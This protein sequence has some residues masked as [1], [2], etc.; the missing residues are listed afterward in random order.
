MTAA[1]QPMLENSGDIDAPASDLDLALAPEPETSCTE[2]NAVAACDAGA[3]GPPAVDRA[4]VLTGMILHCDEQRITLPA[5]PMAIREAC[6]ER[7]LAYALR[8]VETA[9]RKTAFV[10]SGYK[11]ESYDSYAHN[12]HS[13]GGV[14]AAI[15][16][17]LEQVEQD[18]QLTD[19]W[20]ERQAV[21][22]YREAVTPQKIYDKLGHYT[23][24]MTCDRS[25]AIKA[26][27]LIGKKRGLLGAKVVHEHKGSISLLL[28]AVASRGKPTLEAR[29]VR[30]VDNSTGQVTDC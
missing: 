8:Y 25:N 2:A 9:N 17:I 5:L 16:W 19:D 7:Q 30:T 22:L 29:Q 21:R 1:A 11:P 15:V 3:A 14:Q 27:E 23:G 4:N 18:Q 6:N 24:L 13:H 12:V 26:L 10:D 20:L 28:Q